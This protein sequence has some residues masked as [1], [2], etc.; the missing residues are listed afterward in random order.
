VIFI[1]QAV[2]DVINAETLRDNWLAY[3]VGLERAEA[4]G[5]GVS[6]GII[7][8]SGITVGDA[9]TQAESKKRASI[10]QIKL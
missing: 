2:Y 4:C 3:F 7:L 5:I 6:D 10:K 1:H 8:I 9:P